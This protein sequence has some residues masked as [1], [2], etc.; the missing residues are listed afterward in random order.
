MSNYPSLSELLLA[1]LPELDMPKWVKV[2]RLI[3]SNPI[4]EFQWVKNLD[5]NGLM[6]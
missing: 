5:S 4:D 3:Q 6:D 2:N 1:L